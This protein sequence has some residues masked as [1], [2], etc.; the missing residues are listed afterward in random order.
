MSIS[1]LLLAARPLAAGLPAGYAELDT[2]VRDALAAVEA[3]SRAGAEP[4]ASPLDPRLIARTAA[5]KNPEA[6]EAL[7]RVRKGLIAVRKELG[8]PDVSVSVEASDFTRVP[9]FD[10][11][12]GNMLALSRVFP[13]GD[14]LSRR[15]QAVFHGARRAFHEYEAVLQDMLRDARVAAAELYSSRRQLQILDENIALSMQLAEV[16][17]VRYATGLAIQQDVLKAQVEAARYENERLAMERMEGVARAMLNQLLARPGDTPLP[18]AAVPATARS[19]ATAAELEAIAQG[20]RPEILAAAAALAQAEAELGATTADRSRPD[21]E[22]QV[23]YMENP[24]GDSSA[25]QAMVKIN[26]PWFSARRDSEV[27]EAVAGKEGERRRLDA[28][29]NRTSFLIHEALLRVSEAERSVSLFAE[30]LLPQARQTLDSA[31]A[32][33]ETNQTDF[34]TVVDA[35]RSL[36]ESSMAHVRAVADLA[37]RLAELERAVGAPGGVWA[38]QEVRR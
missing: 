12:Q 1:L 25:W 16:A 24:R 15:A 28:V 34:L 27:A 21:L 5:A 6:I 23:G 37:R 35:Q 2:R 4:L 38:V 19:S 11:A 3:A 18:P 7:T 30:R 20:S 13:L 29:R 17:R 33:Y 22:G 8:L 14:K 36:E 10:S 9:E 32:N 26:M 31:R